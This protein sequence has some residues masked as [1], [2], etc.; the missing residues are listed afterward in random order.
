VFVSVIPIALP[1]FISYNRLNN[2]FTENI[3]NLS[4][5]NVNQTRD[6][7]EIILESYEDLLYQLYTD[8]ALISLLD[9]IDAQ[10]DFLPVQINH[11]RMTLRAMCNIKDVIESVTIITAGGNAIFYD[12]ISG[13]FTSSSWLDSG[14]L[15]R[16]AVYERGM[17]DYATGIIPTHYADNYARPYYLFHLTHRIIDYRHI[18]RDIGLVILS[19]S[20]ELLSGV[21]NSHMPAGSFGFIMDDT[22][23]VIS[24]P[25][26]TKIGAILDEN[27]NIRD[28]VSTDKKQGRYLEAYTSSAVRNW[29]VISVIDQSSFHTEAAAQMRNIL[30]MGI[31]FLAATSMVI[32]AITVLL[33]RSLDKVTG[34]MKQAEQGNLNVSIQER[35]I[36]PR[37]TAIIVKAFNTMMERIAGLVDK[38]R[39]ISGEQR[40]AEIKALEAQINPHFLY[41]I[42]DSINWIAIEKEQIEISRA[43]VSLAKILR[44][45]INRS[46]TIVPLRDEVEWIKQYLFLQQVRYKNSFSYTLDVDESLLDI[47]IH[48]LLFQPFIENAIIHG[49]KNRKANN[50]L[51][52]SIAFDQ[53]LV[54]TI[55][56]NGNGMKT[57]ILKMFS[58]ENKTPNE[59]HI[60]IANAVKRIK[61][62][63]GDDAAIHAESRPNEGAAITIILKGLAP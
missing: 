10:N 28:F 18:D 62:Y 1:Q 57:E 49:F 9:E 54:I 7:L 31:V 47:R 6:N 60:G 29:K 37:E 23:R 17:K 33:S 22:N 63:Y 53:G 4:Q 52:I 20:E 55:Q 38:I 40:E 26:K 48:K 45:S 8:D 5:I 12:M 50:V 56:D 30:L 58:E 35:N 51:R 3:N 24:Y 13:S 46:N 43:I 11:V 34:A 14:G 36:F 19:L 15:T 39:I 41:N 2:Y 25:D 61:M 27:A 21:C 16:R 32:T 42:L 44:Y 59:D